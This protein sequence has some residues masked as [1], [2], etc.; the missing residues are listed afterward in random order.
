MAKTATVKVGGYGREFVRIEQT[1][2]YPVELA[3]DSVDLA[4]LAADGWEVVY[5][6]TTAPDFRGSKPLGEDAEYYIDWETSTIDDDEPES[7][8]ADSRDAAGL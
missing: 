3:I 5:P 4:K 6:D 2:H 8:Y 7:A 1:G